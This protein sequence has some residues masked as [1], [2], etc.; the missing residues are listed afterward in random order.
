MEIKMKWKDEKG[1]DDTLII[2]GS[3]ELIDFIK[4][5]EYMQSQYSNS[6]YTNAEAERDKL[7]EQLDDLMRLGQQSS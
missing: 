1:N 3:Y 6:R 7:A 2:N 4:N 5:V